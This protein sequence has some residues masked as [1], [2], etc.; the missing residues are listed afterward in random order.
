MHVDR[1][2]DLRDSVLLWH[3]PM[4]LMI[5]NANNGMLKQWHCHCIAN[6]A[7]TQCSSFLLWSVWAWQQET[8]LGLFIVF[9]DIHFIF[10]LYLYS[11]YFWVFIM[12]FYGILYIS[13]PVLLLKESEEAVV[14]E[15]MREWCRLRADHIIKSHI[16]HSELK[17]LPLPST[18]LSVSLYTDSSHQ[19]LSRQEMKPA[20]FITDIIIRQLSQSANERLP[21]S[22]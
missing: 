15:N 13:I 9:F 3:Q 10:I 2:L 16:F 19:F 20:Q 21:V 1:W 17:L 22:C 4:S 5:D 11:I 8:H 7:L 14:Y 18:L 12:A 6:E